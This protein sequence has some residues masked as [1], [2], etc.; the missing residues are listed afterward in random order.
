MAA[1][2]TAMGRHTAD[3][4]LKRCGCGA[5]WR[6]SGAN[7]GKGGRKGIVIRY[8]CPDVNFLVSRVGVISHLG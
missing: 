4:E 6:G 1:A 7:E 2:V 5:L 8:L 3:A